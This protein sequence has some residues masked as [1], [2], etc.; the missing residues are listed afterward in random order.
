MRSKTLL[1]VLACALLV[2]PVVSAAGSTKAHEAV[3]HRHLVSKDH[4]LAQRRAYLHHHRVRAS[5]VAVISTWSNTRL[6]HDIRKLRR[7]TLGPAAIPWIHAKL[8]RIALC[9]SHNNPRAVNPSGAYRGKYQFSFSTWRA[10]GGHGDPA[11]APSW[12]QDRR[13]GIALRRWGAGQWPVCGYR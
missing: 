13:A 1:A 11:A 4:R 10:V 3:F 7:E 2:V 9:E 12:E 6:V 5:R 8:K